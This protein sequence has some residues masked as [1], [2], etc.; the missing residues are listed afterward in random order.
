MPRESTRGKL[1]TQLTRASKALDKVTDHL[2]TLDVLADGKH[3]VVTEH[4]PIALTIIVAL[5][6]YFQKFRAN[7]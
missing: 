4:V 1:K 2:H 3:T 7:I 6:E 5:Q